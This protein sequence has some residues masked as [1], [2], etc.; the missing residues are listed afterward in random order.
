VKR[1]VLLLILAGC[2]STQPVDEPPEVP[3]GPALPYKV[4][5]SLPEVTFDR[6]DLNGD[7][8]QQYALE[9]D[10][11][12]LQETLVEGLREDGLFR[13]VEVAEP[14][15]GSPDPRERA[16]L[17]LTTRIRKR[18]ASYVGK[19]DL[20]LTNLLIWFMAMVPSWWVRDETYAM[21]MEA[22]VNLR[23]VH[24]GRSIHSGMRKVRIDKDLDDFERGWQFLG[25]FRVPSSLEPENWR[26]VDEALSS[27]TDRAMAT[28]IG[29]EL[30]RDL[31]PRWGTEEF[32][33]SLARRFAVIVGLSFYEDHVI[34]RLKYAHKDARQIHAY[35][36]GETGI[37][38]HNARL[39]EDDDGTRG[40][41][42]SAVEEFARRAEDE[43]DEILVYFAGYGAWIGET[44]YLLPYDARTEALEET[45]ISLDDLCR[46]LSGTGGPQVTLVVDAP[47]IQEFHGREKEGVPG[48]LEPALRGFLS[49]PGRLAIMA[50]GVGESC[51]ELAEYE[52]GVFTHYLLQGLEQ[53]GHRDLDGASA[54]RGAFPHAGNRT[55]AQARLE[56]RRQRPVL[57]ESDATTAEREVSLGEEVEVR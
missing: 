49:P 44:A 46:D 50:C 12:R 35:L 41:I 25:I 2:G 26:A 10:P 36:V 14:H 48:D 6:A 29:W 55:A 11:G 20:Y 51:Q 23:S 31:L 40:A 1:L 15:E 56:G 45:A 33:K 24:S 27:E 57:F 19:G 42:L 5:V 52:N 21:E 17:V 3:L 9:Y 53:E 39:L 7:P 38:V 13:D 4:V 28:R 54:W 16:D 43:N 37:P 8:T 34:H 47:F 22:E 32:R 30:G 18:V